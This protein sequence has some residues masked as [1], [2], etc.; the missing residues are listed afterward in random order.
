VTPALCFE[1]T[2]VE[3]GGRTVLE[4]LDVAAAPGE[5]VGLIGPNGAGKTT[6]LRAAAGLVPYTG[7]VRVCGREV[8]AT[9]G[10]RLARDL[11]LVPQSP[12]TPADLRVSEY[13]L[14]GRNPYVSY[15]GSESRA[16]LDAAAR[17]MRRLDLDRFAGR[18]LG[19]LSGGERQ[20]A[21][22]ARALAQEPSLLL[23][24]EP[25]G[26]LDIGRQQFVLELVDCLRRDYGL[27][28]IV[29]M[30]DL[31]LAAQYADRLLLLSGGRVV[32]DGTPTEVLTEHNVGGHYRARVA[33]VS[34]GNGA[35]A[36][37]P[38][39]AAPAERERAWRP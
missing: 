23:L 2:S 20:R 12:A 17:A 27:T 36:V 16:D 9:P 33:L 3:L 39:R 10:R 30:H 6:A 14:L 21:V 32:A 1:A 26:A 11:A 24:D 7:S 4:R 28:V 37:I 8:S 38:S 15:F 22:L 5:W 18:E 25:T 29:A 19:S 34:A 35:L 13:V 31:V